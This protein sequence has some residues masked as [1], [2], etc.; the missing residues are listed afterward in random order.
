MKKVILGCLLVFS[1]VGVGAVAPQVSYAKETRFTIQGPLRPD[2]G[3]RE[4]DC[5]CWCDPVGLIV[6]TGLVAAGIYF[7]WNALPK[8]ALG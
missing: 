1:L 2:D 7:F 6:G 8:I 3:T 4:Y 5:A